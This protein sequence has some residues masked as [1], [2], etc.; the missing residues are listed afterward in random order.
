MGKLL[1]SKLIM[2]FAMF[3][4]LAVMAQEQYCVFKVEGKPMLNDSIPL[5]KGVFIN[6]GQF[7][8]LDEKDKVV[9]LDETGAI[10]E[11]DKKMYIPF[12]N[13]EKFTK[14]PE[15]TSFTLKYLKFIWDKLWQEEE[16]ENIGVVFRSDWASI[17]L[18]PA[19]SVFI[20]GSDVVFNWQEKQTDET[21]YLFLRNNDEKE[22]LKLST[23]GNTL[24]LPVN[25]KILKS[26]SSYYWSVSSER[27]PEMKDL[28]FHSFYLL[29]EDSFN[30]KMREFKEVWKEFEALG[31]TED[32]IKNSFCEDKGLCFD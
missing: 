3:M 8:K 31:F 14:R 10:Y 9:L 13:I 1:F 11:L 12:K 30:L 23:N 28:Y 26:D 2:L 20:Y 18:K 22:Y 27:E 4:G 29:G 5:Q 24:T 6:T 16:K 17:P 25:D 15:Q 21:N 19:D 7:L 32:E